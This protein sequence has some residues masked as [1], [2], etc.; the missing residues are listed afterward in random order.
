MLYW[1]ALK[2][3]Y[4]PSWTLAMHPLRVRARVAISTVQ[5]EWDLLPEGVRR[6]MR[7]MGDKGRGDAYGMV[8]NCKHY[9]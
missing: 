8:L 3:F 5:Q 7:T 6:V 9:Q 4:V 1:T 2:V